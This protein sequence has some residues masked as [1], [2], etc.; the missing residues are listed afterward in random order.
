MHSIEEKMWIAFL[1]NFKKVATV[2]GQKQKALNRINM[3]LC[4]DVDKIEIKLTDFVFTEQTL[5]Q[6]FNEIFG[7]QCDAVATLMYMKAS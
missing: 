1:Q 4:D 7:Y 3:K 6:G 5:R 2:D